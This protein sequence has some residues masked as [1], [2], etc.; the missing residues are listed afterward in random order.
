MLGRNQT[1]LSR[2]LGTYSGTWDIQTAGHFL[3]RTIFGPKRTEINSD[4]HEI[5]VDLS[6]LTEGFYLYRLKEASVSVTNKLKKD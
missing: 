2:S 4:F 3:R 5:R 1:S 6:Y